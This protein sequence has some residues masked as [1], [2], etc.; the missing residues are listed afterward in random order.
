MINTCV[1]CGK[2][3]EAIKSTKKYCSTECSNA[4][5]RER[6]AESKASKKTIELGPDN[7]KNNCPEK[8]CLIC[9]K[10]FK[11]KTST[12]NQRTC[13]YECM[14]EGKQLTRT[15]FLAKIKEHQGGKCI[16]CGYNTCI[17]A[18]EFHHLDPSKKDF[19]ISNDHFR[20][21]DTVEEVKKC[22]LLCAN[23]HRE[24]HANLW[25]I[26]ELKLDKREEEVES[27]GINE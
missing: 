7:R 13:C 16:R 18:L 21:R 22:V 2:K 20:L 12:A 19:T 26:N 4:S 15:D 1:I 10:I 14:P 9:G 11:P 27:D 8:A 23:C 3:F 6:Y 17:K 25:D 5:R 24:L